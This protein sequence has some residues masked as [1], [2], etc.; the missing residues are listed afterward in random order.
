MGRFVTHASSVRVTKCILCIVTNKSLFYTV[1]NEMRQTNSFFPLKRRYSKVAC[2]LCTFPGRRSKG[3][4]RMVVD[5]SLS[6]DSRDSSRRTCSRNRDDLTRSPISR[7]AR[8]HCTRIR[9]LHPQG[10]KSVGSV[11]YFP[12]NDANEYTS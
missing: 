8:V 6:D 11:R 2:V 10:T 7:T 12:S 3:A 1:L 5:R 4:K 9:C